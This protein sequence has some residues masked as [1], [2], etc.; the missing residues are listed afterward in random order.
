MYFHFTCAMLRRNV[1]FKFVS[2]ARSKS[3]RERVFLSFP[4][5]NQAF[6]RAYADPSAK[7]IFLLLRAQT[8]P[9]PIDAVQQGH[10][11]APILDFAKEIAIDRDCTATVCWSRAFK[12][13]RYSYGRVFSAS[14]E[15]STL[16]TFV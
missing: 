5:A 16:A 4:F 6:S 7:F 2:C 15:I 13:F 11:I 12:Q 10:S 9:R 8:L 14:A 3:P 1:A